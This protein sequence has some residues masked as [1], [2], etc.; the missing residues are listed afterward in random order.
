MIESKEIAECVGLWL[1]EGDKKTDRE[2]TFTNN[3]MEL[4]FF[5]HN[6]IKL[7]YKGKN[8]PR[9]YT[10]SPTDRVLISELQDFVVR[11]YM[12]KR[13][14][15]TYFIYRLADVDFVKEWKMVVDFVKNHEEHYPEILRGIFAGEGNIKHDFE[16]NNSRNLRISAG[17]RDLFIEKLLIYFN[18]KFSY[19][20]HKR[21]Y[22]ITGRHLDKLKE[23]NIASLHPEKEAKFR[24]MFECLKE[25]HYS[26]GEL[27]T[28]LLR[29][30]NEFKKTSELAIK[31]QK[32]DLRMSEALCELKKEGRIGVVRIKGNSYWVRKEILN[33]YLNSERIKLLSH[34]RKKQTMTAIGKFLNLS[35]KSIRNRLIKLEIEGLVEKKGG[36]WMVKEESKTVVGIDE[37]G[38]E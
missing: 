36:Y 2:V 18:V 28:V 21:Q 12:D 26:P 38:S 4:I 17:W 8:K 24:K 37:S 15:R 20:E 6:T 22:V 31:F 33:E 27:K 10:Y 16:N 7:L 23:I 5:F 13:A 25:K 14:N 11:N 30:L 35:R 3:C 29:D 32:S 9:I 19:E 1:A 34:V